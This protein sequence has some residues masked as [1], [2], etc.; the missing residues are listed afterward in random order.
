MALAN[1]RKAFPEKPEAEIQDIARDMWGNMARLAAEYVFIEK[2]FDF[3][4]EANEPGRIEV[5]GE[6]RFI[7]VRA[8]PRPHIFFTAHLGN[9][10]FCRSRPLPSIST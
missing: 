10:S 6:E 4:P 5:V 9:S 7:E 8:D 3:D 2:L 1:L